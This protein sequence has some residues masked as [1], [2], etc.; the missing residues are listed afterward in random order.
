MK[1]NDPIPTVAMHSLRDGRIARV[2]RSPVG[3]PLSK[4]VISALIGGAH[5][6]CSVEIPGTPFRAY[7]SFKTL[8][9]GTAF[10]W[11]CAGQSLG[12]GKVRE[13]SI[14]YYCCTAAQLATAPLA[15]RHIMQIYLENLVIAPPH[16]TFN[17]PRPMPKT[18][19]PWGCGF[20]TDESIHLLPAERK[21]LDVIIA[22]AA[23]YVANRC[24]DG[25]AAA[26]QRGRF[27]QVDTEL[28]PELL[29]WS[30]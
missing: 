30:D 5:G 9:D 14:L 17:A 29:E 26:H 4:A 13:Q 10:W 22:L 27:P 28:F 23:G 6:N 15:W 19:L 24:G 3:H 11:V 2:S 7:A 20:Y 12:N 16:L 21:E 8:S 25:C 18:E 1:R